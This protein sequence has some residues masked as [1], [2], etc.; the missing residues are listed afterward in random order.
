MNDARE[1]MTR[2]LSIDLIP[3]R[4]VVCRLAPGAPVPE[5]ALSGAFASVTRTPDELSV[6]C[7]EEAVPAGVTTARDWRCLRFQGPFAFEETGVLASVTAPLA[8]AGIS[9]F[10]LS[11]Y[12]TDYVLVR[13]GDLARAVAALREA[14]HRVS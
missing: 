9:L 6:V 7:A 2:V 13:D 4:Y 5:W 3:G 12:D 10:A 14:G 1:A 8:A 11:T